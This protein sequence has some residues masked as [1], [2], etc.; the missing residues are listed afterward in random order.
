MPKCGETHEILIPHHKIFQCLN[1]EEMTASRDN[2][3]N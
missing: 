3:N 2:D 1:E